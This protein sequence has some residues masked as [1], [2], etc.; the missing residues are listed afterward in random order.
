MGDGVAARGAA[1]DPGAGHGYFQHISAI[2]ITSGNRGI[3]TN[4]AL[5]LVQT[6]RILCDARIYFN[7]YT[8][9][10]PSA[11]TCFQRAWWICLPIILIRCSPNPQAW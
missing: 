7:I 2:E 11:W 5:S 6:V 9:A 10:D 1:T 8:G 3:V 4:R